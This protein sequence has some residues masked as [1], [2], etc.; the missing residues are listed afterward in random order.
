M[1]RLKEKEEKNKQDRKK[2]DKDLK[3][4]IAKFYTKEES[5]NMGA[6]GL[7]SID[8]YKSSEIKSE[9]TVNVDRIVGSK[10]ITATKT[11]TRK[12]AMEEIKWDH[13]AEEFIDFSNNNGEPEIMS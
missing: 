10:N 3:K 5:K 11:K 12:E 6:S 1:I 9:G 4:D 7:D 13:E 8:L 2:A